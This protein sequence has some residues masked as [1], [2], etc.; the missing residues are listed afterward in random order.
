LLTD[1]DDG[2]QV[3]QQRG[4]H[5]I[6]HLAGGEQ[7]HSV[8]ASRQRWP[9][10]ASSCASGQQSGLILESSSPNASRRGSTLPL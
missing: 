6:V 2:L 3:A 1:G 9:A 10:C 5:S 4:R 8:S 7:D